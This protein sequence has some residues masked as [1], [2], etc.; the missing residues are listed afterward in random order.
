MYAPVFFTK[1]QYAP[2][3]DKSFPGFEVRFTAKRSL[4]A[5]ENAYAPNAV[6]AD[7]SNDYLQLSSRVTATNTKTGH[8]AMFIKPSANVSMPL[9]WTADLPGPFYQSRVDIDM[10]HITGGVFNPRIRLWNTSNTAILTT[11]TQQVVVRDVWNFVGVSWD[12]QNNLFSAVVN[13]SFVNTLAAAWDSGDA[14][15][16]VYSNDTPDWAECDLTRIFR[17]NPNLLPSA[18]LAGDMCNFSVGQGYI[19]WTS[20]AKQLEYFVANASAAPSV[21]DHANY[22]DSKVVQLTSNAANYG[23]N[24]AGADFTINGA[25]VDATPPEAA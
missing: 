19:D 23:S 25:F 15:V 21:V 13:N 12:L 4:T 9:F 5:A 14:R 17:T 16:S 11:N 7:G 8:L 10:P 1:R 3:I 18:Q 22:T 2:R 6:T 20:G 24:D